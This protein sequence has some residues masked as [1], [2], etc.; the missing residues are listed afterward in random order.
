MQF[1]GRACWKLVNCEQTCGKRHANFRL[2]FLIQFSKFCMVI[3]HESSTKVFGP[4]YILWNFLRPVSE[5]ACS[6]GAS[7]PA[8]IYIQL[9]LWTLS[10]LV[11]KNTVLN[12]VQFRVFQPRH[13]VYQQQYN[14][15]L[16]LCNGLSLQICIRQPQNMAPARRIQRSNAIHLSGTV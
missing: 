9:I 16:Q 3:S 11:T 13:G 1:V 6:F 5:S 4:S 7:W 15:D 2:A 8:R 10:F 14:V 12:L